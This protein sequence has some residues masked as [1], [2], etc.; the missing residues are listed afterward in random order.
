MSDPY[1]KLRP[2]PPT[3]EDELCDCANITEIYLAHKLGGNPVHCLRCNGEV[4][5]DRLGFSEEIAEAIAS[6]NS[7]YGALYQLWLDSGEYEVYSRDRLLEP[8]GQ[9]NSNGI[10]L[11][12]KL[13]SFAKAYY[14]WFYESCDTAPEKCPLCGS[15]LTVKEGCKFKLCEPCF[16]IV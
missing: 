4:L 10:E 11:A 1:F 9:V 12:R 13:G 8:Y 7:V 15:D 2:E 5:P 3:P 16:I 6:W 14:L